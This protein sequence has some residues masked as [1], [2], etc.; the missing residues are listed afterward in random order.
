MILQLQQEK[1]LFLP[2]FSFK[3][4]DGNLRAFSNPLTFPFTHSRPSLPPT[5]P[6]LPEEEEDSPEEL[7]SSSSSPRTVS[8]N[9]APVWRTHSQIT[10]RQCEVIP[11]MLRH[12]SDFKISSNMLLLICQEEHINQNIILFNL[13]PTVQTEAWLCGEKNWSYQNYNL[14]YCYLNLNL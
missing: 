3:K 10:Q 8:A 14:N 12:K 5:M 9:S 6:T 2:E 11:S 7:D 4:G 1:K 13:L